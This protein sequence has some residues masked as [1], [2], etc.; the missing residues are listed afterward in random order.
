MLECT[1]LNPILRFPTTS[2]GQRVDSTLSVHQWRPPCGS[3][4]PVKATDVFIFKFWGARP[5][6]GAPIQPRDASYPLSKRH[7]EPADRKRQLQE[8][9]VRGR[10]CNPYTVVSSS[11]IYLQP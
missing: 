9:D 2:G 1:S 4:L 11:E 3:G 8:R 6:T 7:V 10:G 5:L